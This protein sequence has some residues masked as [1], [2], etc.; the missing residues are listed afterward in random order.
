MTN[1]GGVLSSVQISLLA[2]ADTVATNSLRDGIIPTTAVMV[3]SI[4]SLWRSSSHPRYD[5]IY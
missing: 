2:H 4:E 3:E 5:Q 1:N